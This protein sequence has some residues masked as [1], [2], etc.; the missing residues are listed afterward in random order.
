MPLAEAVRDGFDLLDTIEQSAQAAPSAPD[1]PAAAAALTPRER[2]ILQLVADGRT[3][4]EIADALY[5]SLRTVQ[6]HVA[7][8]LAK[9]DLTSRAAVA[10]YAV[11]HGL[12]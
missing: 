8:I 5:I 12:V 10:A 3:N 11:R 9:L 1:L 4:Q 2:E 6:T 7:N